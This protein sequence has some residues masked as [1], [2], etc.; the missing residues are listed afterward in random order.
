MQAKIERIFQ[1]LKKARGEGVLE[2]NLLTDYESPEN[3][4]GIRWKLNKKHPIK[5]INKTFDDTRAVYTEIV[6]GELRWLL[7]KDYWD[8]G[9]TEFRDLIKRQDD[10]DMR[11]GNKVFTVIMFVLA[12]SSII[13][14]WNL[15]KPNNVYECA[16]RYDYDLEMVIETEIW[17]L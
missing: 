10:R 16:E 3:T 17:Q 14:G 12:I 8:V 9:I 1:A 5:R 4:R 15:G 2:V 6:N 11:F 7:H 13:I